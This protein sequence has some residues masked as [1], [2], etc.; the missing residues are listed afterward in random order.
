MP[1]L[2]VWVLLSLIVS[3]QAGA[4]LTEGEARHNQEIRVG[5]ALNAVLLSRMQKVIMVSAVVATLGAVYLGW[6]TMEE[7][8]LSLSGAGLL[9]IGHLLSVARYS[10][11]NEPFVFRV[12]YMWVYPA[13]LLGGLA[14]AFASSRKSKLICF[15]AAIPA[16][17]YTFI[18]TAKAGVLFAACC[19]LS[20]YLAMRVV[21]GAERFRALNGKILMVSAISVFAV[22]VLL[23]VTDAI[24]SHSQ[25]QEDV[26]LT[27][28]SARM[29]ASVFGYLSAFSQWMSGSRQEELGFGA[30]TFGG[31]FDL[32]GLH[33]RAIGV[34]T[35][36]VTL[37]GLEENNVYTAFRGL[38]QDFSF[39]VAIVICAALGA[40]CGY[41]YGQLRRGRFR[42]ALGVSAFYAFVAWSPLGSLFVY[43][44]LIL[45]WCIAAVLLMAGPHRTWERKS[46]SPN[47]A[48]EA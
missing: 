29:K 15:A 25:E 47:F 26:E 1:S 10:G 43:N 38:I 11:E 7:N 4:W 46:V 37:P 33:P 45:A 3:I 41:G 20:G 5:A 6:R 13:A 30:Y 24:R 35:S 42:W 8:G 40:L 9:A 2:G 21:R 34:Y 32:A 28:D 12:L 48:Q 44:G 19:W 31:L 17:L 14:F 16:L 39:P 27:V 22:I 36:S 23:V 18:E